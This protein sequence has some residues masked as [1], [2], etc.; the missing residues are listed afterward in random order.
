M[1]ASNET[2]F[3]K[4]QAPPD[5]ISNGCYL[6]T[7]ELKDNFI[8]SNLRKKLNQHVKIKLAI[9]ISGLLLCFCHMENNELGKGYI[10]MQRTHLGQCP[11]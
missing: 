6:P 5:Y 2:L 8:F 1:A 4:K 9:T 11:F 10:S 3:T 7:S